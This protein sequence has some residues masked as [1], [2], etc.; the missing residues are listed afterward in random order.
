MFTL[1][2]FPIA[3]RIQACRQACFSCIDTL[4][5]RYRIYLGEQQRKM[6]LILCHFGEI[7]KLTLNVSA[8]RACEW[9]I[10]YKKYGHCPSGQICIPSESVTL[11]KMVSLAAFPCNAIPIRLWRVNRCVARNLIQAPRKDDFPSGRTV[12]RAEIA[13]TDRQGREKCP[14]KHFMR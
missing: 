1:A 10:T 9:L 2:R 3:G 8:L 12:D 6:Q 14:Q 4:A 13:C 11:S 7:V 5:A